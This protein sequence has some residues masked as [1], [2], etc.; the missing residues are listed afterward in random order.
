M[1]EAETRIIID[2]QLRSAGWEVD[3]ET[4]RFSKGSRPQMG[5]YRAIAEWPVDKL[6][7]DYALFYENIFIGI[8]EA[9]KFA[10]DVVSDLT[11]AKESEISYAL[12]IKE[13]FPNGESM[14]D[15][16]KR[17]ASTGVVNLFPISSSTVHQ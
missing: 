9:K 10:K 13:K 2:E 1:N 6:F 12:H 16:E 17:I 11:Q 5:K 14:E 15:V 7:A 8:A 3:T 4:L